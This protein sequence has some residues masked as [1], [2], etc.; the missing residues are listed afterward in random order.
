MAQPINFFQNKAVDFTTVVTNF[1]VNGKF[2]MV[3]HGEHRVE[4]HERIR[5]WNLH[6]DN[7]FEV[8][9]S[10]QPWLPFFQLL[11]QRYAH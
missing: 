7:L 5:L 11:Q 8:R 1:W 4:V 2:I 6:G 9:A 10:K 3:N